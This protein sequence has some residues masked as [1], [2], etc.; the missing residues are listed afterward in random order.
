MREKNPPLSVSCRFLL[1]ARFQTTN[2]RLIRIKSLKLLTVLRPPPLPP[3]SSDAHVLT[4]RGPPKTLLRRRHLKLQPKRKTVNDESKKLICV[5]KTPAIR[6]CLG[7]FYFIFNISTFL[8]KV[9]H[10]CKS[11]FHSRR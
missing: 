9:V 6:L 1:S 5:G 8:T 2:L 10:M 4:S 7:Q 11:C 3:R